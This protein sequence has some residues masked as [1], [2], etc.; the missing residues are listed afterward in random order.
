MTTAECAQ[1]LCASIAQ[2][3]TY[4]SSTESPP[5]IVVPATTVV[6]ELDIVN[7]IAIEGSKDFSGCPVPSG[8]GEYTVDLTAMTTGGGMTGADITT[9]T[10]GLAGSWDV[11]IPFTA[12]NAQYL[13]DYRFNA[14][15]LVRAAILDSSG[16]VVPIKDQANWAGGDCGTIAIL[17][18]GPG[19]VRPQVQ[20]AVAPGN[21]YLH[22]TGINQTDNLRNLET[23]PTALEAPGACLTFIV[24]TD[25]TTADCP[26][27]TITHVDAD[28]LRLCVC[29]DEDAVEILYTQAW[30]D[31]ATN[32]N[33][34]CMPD[35][36]TAE[37]FDASGAQ[38]GFGGVDSDFITANTTF[39]G[40]NYDVWIPIARA[41]GKS[42]LD[43]NWRANDGP[44]RGVLFD[45]SGADVVFP[46][47]ATFAGDCGN[48]ESDNA[49][50]DGTG[51]ID[52]TEATQNGLDMGTY[53]LHFTVINSGETL[54]DVYA[55]PQ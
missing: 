37:Q 27:G 41:P 46:G 33:Q 3:V 48:V 39:A 45:P 50:T 19:A 49:A 14:S 53:Y 36:G 40:P 11:W 9:A 13:P 22:I 43:L 21:Y 5:P 32:N 55:A 7:A 15:D 17:T 54:S 24:D 38:P 4:A 16:D 51:N 28:G 18:D 8:A 44:I 34:G 42:W 1:E 12:T 47:S 26:A 35:F 10:G 30:A 29:G 23:D 2:V 31:S 52:P 25:T 20:T 6:P